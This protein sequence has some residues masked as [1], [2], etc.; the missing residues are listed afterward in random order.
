MP[1]YAVDYIKHGLLVDPKWQEGFK[2]AGTVLIATSA[3]LVSFFPS[4]SH[5]ASPFLGFFFGHIL[6]A[7]MGIVRRDKPLIAVN[8]FFIPIDIYAMYIRL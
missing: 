4:L 3:I 8:G 5:H 7:S 1:W 6:W 2:W